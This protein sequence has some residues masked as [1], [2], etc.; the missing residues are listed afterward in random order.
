M[1]HEGESKKEIAERTSR[2]NK[3]GLT[4]ER[5]Q[6]IIAEILTMKKANDAVIN[7]NAP[8]ASR[9]RMAPEQD[10]Y[11]TQPSDPLR[12]MQDV[13]SQPE[14]SLEGKKVLTV[15]GSGDLPLFFLSMGAEQTDAFDISAIACVMTEAKLTAIKSDC[16]S[17]E[18][19]SDMFKI[20]DLSN[21]DEP[22]NLETARVFFQA[23]NY[24]ALEPLL[25]PQAKQ[26]LQLAT[27]PETRT[28]LFSYDME[29]MGMPYEVFRDR[30]YMGGI[31]LADIIPLLSN[32]ELFA[33]YQKSLQRQRS[34]IRKKSLFHMTRR[35]LAPYDYVFVSNI[36]FDKASIIFDLKN[37]LMKGVKR[38]GFTI[39]AGGQHR[40]ENKNIMVN[41]NGEALPAN[42][43]PVKNNQPIINMLDQ[44]LIPGTTVEMF[45]VNIRIL[46]HDSSSP[47]IPVYAEMRAEDNEH[48]FSKQKTT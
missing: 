38:I 33:K 10:I 32:P 28:L 16:L 40:Q 45:G 35:D 31:K 27:D 36:G 39:Q 2:Y 41:W 1:H 43:Q 5:M 24:D 18:Q 30:Q 44:D 15:A 11:Y 20:P 48:L 13:L 19:Y 17:L 47:T 3:D 29:N 6:E 7:G 21:L 25:T 23:D 37:M 9:T 14:Y 12:L 22:E 8:E 4:V 46:C 26:F 34:R 42:E